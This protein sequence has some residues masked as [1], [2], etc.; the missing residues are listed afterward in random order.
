M[1]NF[2][3]IFLLFI[4]ILFSSLA[5]IPAD[6]KKVDLNECIQIGLQNHPDLRVSLENIDLAK[7]AYKGTQALKR[8]QVSLNS[9]S[10][11]R[12][13]PDNDTSNTDVSVPGKETEFA[14]F[15]GLSASY[16][17]VKPDYT[18]K[19]EIDK[20]NIDLANLNELKTRFSVIYKIKLAYLNYMNAIRAFEMRHQTEQNYKKRLNI[21]Q[22]LVKNGERPVIDLSTSEV[23][24]AQ[25]ALNKENA[26]N[27]EQQMRSELFQAM[28]LFEDNGVEFHPVNISQL[29]SLKYNLEG[30]YK[31][32]ESNALSIREANLTKEKSRLNISKARALNWPTVNFRTDFG[33]T[34]PSFDENG[35]FVKDRPEGDISDDWTPALAVSINAKLPLYTGGSIS[36]KVDASIA[37]Y[38][39]SKFV[40]RKVVLKT[41]KEI[42]NVYNKLEE[43][44]KQMNIY[45]LNVANARTNVKLTEKSY[46]SGIGT[47]EA[48]QNAEVA[49]VDAELIL[50]NSRFNYLKSL[51]VLSNI[52]GLGEN[53]LCVK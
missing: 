46:D 13:K 51:A 20:K 25:V 24:Y 3:R 17:L 10:V 9:R 26:K 34:S 44:K 11:E 4:I 42:K 18:S 37:N 45:R 38:N 48:M 39:K 52:I 23:R 16:N 15:A 27:A 40:A 2:L 31:L 19:I 6:Q 32:S 22:V 8:L 1:R 35:T 28:G 30:L 47:Q 36:A 14:I 21:I 43:L 33:Y 53:Y 29:P 50:I 7:A 49:L 12:R 41:R 5:V